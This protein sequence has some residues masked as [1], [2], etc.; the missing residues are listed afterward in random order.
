M[1]MIITNPNFSFCDFEKETI[2]KTIHIIGTSKKTK[3]AK[4]CK[5]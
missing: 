2:A 5:I 3:E 4:N 1:I